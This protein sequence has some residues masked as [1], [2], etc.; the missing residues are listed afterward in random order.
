MFEETDLFGYDFLR[1]SSVAHVT[2]CLVVRFACGAASWSDG[3]SAT[4]AV[5]S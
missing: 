1:V 5:R 2:D 3:V 4:G